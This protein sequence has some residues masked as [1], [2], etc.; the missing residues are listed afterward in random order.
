MYTCFCAIT[1]TMKK[2]KQLLPKINLEVVFSVL[3]R[4]PLAILFAMFT[5]T[6]AIMMVNDANDAAEHLLP[7]IIMCT[8]LGVLLF[9]NTR[10][11]V[12]TFTLNQLWQFVIE[13]IGL[14]TLFFYFQTLPESLHKLDHRTMPVFFGLHLLLHLSVSF[15][16]YL[17]R[18]KP[19]QFWEYNR[20]I[21]SRFIEATL[22]SFILFAGLSLALLALDYLFGV[23]FNHNKIYAH[24]F[25]TIMSVFNTA[26]FLSRFPKNINELLPSEPNWSYRI[27]TE[28]ILIPLSILYLFILYAY[29]ISI[30]VNGALPEGW[31]SKLVLSFSIIGVLT[32]LLNYINTR[33]ESRRLTKLFLKYFFPAMFLPIILLFVAIY[34]RLEEYGVTEPRYIVATIAV[35]LFGIMIYFIL[36]RI[37]DIRIIP[38]S[39]FLM[40]VFALFSPLNMFNAS[41]D[42]QKNHLILELNELG[43]LSD[44]KFQT[45]SPLERK[46]FQSITSK[47]KFLN[48]RNGLFFLKDFATDEMDLAYIK[49]GQKCSYKELRRIYDDL[50]L[51][52]LGNENKVDESHSYYNSH[53]T[54]MNAPPNST[55]SF[56]DVNQ[57]G[58]GL[59]ING[60]YNFTLVNGAELI[61]SKNEINLDTVSLEYIIDNL[62][63]TTR[64]KPKEFRFDIQSEKFNYYFNFQR[65]RTK[66][67]NFKVSFISLR[68][69][70]F[71][72]TKEYE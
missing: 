26:Y 32:Y 62:P 61:V 69:F 52:E 54:D 1:D 50:G 27:L 21:F 8:T 38:M 63:N 23:E 71:I 6:I 67:I 15:I 25:F 51:K 59:I 17:K 47:I 30:L 4:F 42:S 44:N 72:Q 16:P 53:Y 10:L 68:G 45:I 2:L 5:A 14:L 33:K 24:L 55:F 56:F 48:D 43:V 60:D 31:V 29:A 18:K 57:E 65:I 37:D 36:S 35:W 13:L 19:F 22:Y 28:F 34:V 66:T 7:K 64:G 9:I 3:Q 39:M 11:I 58:F 46:T 40:T 49:E 70:V 41:Y 12:E 20:I